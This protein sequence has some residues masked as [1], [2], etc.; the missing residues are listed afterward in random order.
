MLFTP[1]RGIITLI[2]TTGLRTIGPVPPVVP[3]NVREVVIP[4]VV[5]EELILRQSLLQSPV[6]KLISGQLVRILP[7]TVLPRFRLMVGTHL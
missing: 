2:P 6:P 7:R 4:N 5:L 3:P 1:L